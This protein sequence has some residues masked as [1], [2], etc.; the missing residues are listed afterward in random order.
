MKACAL[1][2]VE[3]RWVSPTDFLLSRYADAYC[4]TTNADHTVT[5]ILVSLFY[6]SV[7]MF[8]SV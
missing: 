7:F 5:L 4:R 3:I 8:I 6:L 1:F 2:G